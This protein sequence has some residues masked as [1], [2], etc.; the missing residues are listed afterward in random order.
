MYVVIPSHPVNI[1]V[2]CRFVSTATA[3]E[4][5][6]VRPI[7]VSANQNGEDE[8]AASPKTCV[9]AGLMSFVSETPVVSQSA[10]VKPGARKLT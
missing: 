10:Q 3:M 8:T 9:I 5:H 4:H 1:I 7:S 6:P 2:W